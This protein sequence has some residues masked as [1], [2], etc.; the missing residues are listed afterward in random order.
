MSNKIKRE[1]AI[2]VK[3]TKIS[4]DKFEGNHLN[5][6]FEG[7]SSEGF[8]TDMPQIGVRYGVGNLLTSMVTQTLDKDNIFK[9]LY[10]TYKLEI[11]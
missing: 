8:V 2:A 6:I 11:L 1:E 5:N 4:D 10:S 3:V 7:Y 9:T